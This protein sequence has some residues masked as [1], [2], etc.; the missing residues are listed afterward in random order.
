GR[1]SVRDY[2]NKTGNQTV[3]GSFCTIVDKL[4]LTQLRHEKLVNYKR[5]KDPQTGAYTNYRYPTFID[6]P[7]DTETDECPYPVEAIN[8]TYD[9]LHPSDKGY[10][11]IS[12]RLGKILKRY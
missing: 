7:F 8:M 5:L 1:D 10:A 4:A 2:Q 11:V 12:K 3:C 6:V 9:G